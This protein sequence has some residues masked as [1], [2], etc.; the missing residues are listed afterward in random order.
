MRDRRRKE[1]QHPELIKA[2]WRGSYEHGQ[3]APVL[4]RTLGISRWTQ[5]W[6]ASTEGISHP[7]EHHAPVV[8]VPLEVTTP[9][10]RCGACGN[11]TRVD[12]CS[13]GVA[14]RRTA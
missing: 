1:R 7:R 12:P 10:R 2:L 6:W 9:L 5:Y 3:S 8:V 13:C 4:E 11:L 14:W